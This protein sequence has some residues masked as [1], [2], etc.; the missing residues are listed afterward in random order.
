MLSRTLLFIL[1]VA[2]TVVG[3]SRW[4]PVFTWPPIPRNIETWGKPSSVALDQQGRLLIFHRGA[5]ALLRFDHTGKMESSW[6]SGFF[7]MAHGLKVA[8][9]GNIWVTD[10]NRHVIVKFSPEG[11][12]LQLLGTPDQPGTGPDHFAG[13][14]DL[15]FLP[16]GD[17][18]VADG[19]R[20]AR[21]V[22]FDKTG[23]FLFEWGKPGKGAGEF[24][25]PHAI[26]LDARGRVYVGDRENKRIQIFDPNG[27]YITEWHTGS[28]Y[29]LA[30]DRE[31]NLWMGDGVE[32][33]VVKIDPNGQPVDSFE[34]PVTHPDGTGAHMLIVGPDGAVYVAETGRFLV[35]KYVKR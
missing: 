6:S 2:Q 35:R 8:P 33:R 24:H 1:T 12:Q 28:P 21:V 16:N 4:A 9:D 34:L 30:F 20:N 17:F 11:K 26:A 13:V 15:A 3:Q 18:Y 22:K 19:Y 10:A 5:P 27:K 29:G 23:K 31:G 32:N 14:A 25:L 7:K